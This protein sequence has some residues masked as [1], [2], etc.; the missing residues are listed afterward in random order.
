MF[1][2]WFRVQRVVPSTGCF[3][4]VLQAKHL[5][6]Q[7]QPDNPTITNLE[8]S[9]II[10]LCIPSEAKYGNVVRKP[11]RNGIIHNGWCVHDYVIANDEEREEPE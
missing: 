4:S 3:L 11:D 8:A 2:E 10:K 6:S 1:R 7:A 5:Y 9:T